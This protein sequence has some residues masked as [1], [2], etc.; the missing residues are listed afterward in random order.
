M[1]I[2]GLVWVSLTGI[3]FGMMF[4]VASGKREEPPRSFMLVW[5]FTWLS[6]GLLFAMLLWG[7]TRWYD[8]HPE[9]LQS[10]HVG[11]SLMYPYSP[12]DVVSQRIQQLASENDPTKEHGILG[13]LHPLEAFLYFVGGGVCAPVGILG[14]KALTKLKGRRHD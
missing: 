3:F 13:D 4:L 5:L 8:L 12:R 7:V 11:D 6:V 2:R 1:L 10:S 14:G 9:K